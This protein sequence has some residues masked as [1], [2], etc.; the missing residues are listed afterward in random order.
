MQRV[1]CVKLH[2]VGR[3][4]SLRL[5]SG[6]ERVYLVGFGMSSVGPGDLETNCIRWLCPS[7]GRV[8]VHLKGG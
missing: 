7:G 2:E 8:V 5:G 3:G 1:L 4:E 6:G